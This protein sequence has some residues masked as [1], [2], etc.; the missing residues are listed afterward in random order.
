MFA[1]ISIYAGMKSI[2]TP[3][4]VHAQWVKDKVSPLIRMGLGS[5]GLLIRTVKTEITV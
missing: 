5:I 1:V 2:E 3:P 4:E